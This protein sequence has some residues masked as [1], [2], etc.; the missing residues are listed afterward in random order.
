MDKVNEELFIDALTTA[1]YEVAPKKLTE[2]ISRITI[3]RYKAYQRTH[4]F[5]HF[6]SLKHFFY[7]Q[8][9]YKLEFFIQQFQISLSMD[10]G[11]IIHY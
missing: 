11:P 7:L 10:C 2:Q 6:A 3:S 5:R 1:Y 4:N 8:Y 9:W